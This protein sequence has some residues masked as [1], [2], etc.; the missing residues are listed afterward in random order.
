MATTTR[1]RLQC[2]GITKA[3]N[4]WL[5]NEDGTPGTQA[6]IELTIAYTN[7]PSNP[8]YPF[9]QQSGGTKFPLVTINESAAAMFEI[10]KE[11]NV[12]ISAAE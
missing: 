2:T 12:D 9:A 4:A 1:V 11:Y 3:Q 5:K 10:G 6:T 8:N 7:D